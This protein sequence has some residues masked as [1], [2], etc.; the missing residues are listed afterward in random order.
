[1]VHF[2]DGSVK[3]QMGVPD[4]RVPILYSLSYPD[5]LASDLP[6][7]DLSRSSPLSFFS[8]DL[9]RFRNLRLAYHA[10][11]EGG[12]MPCILNAANEVAVNAFLAGRIGF[13]QMSDV[14]EHTMEKTEY[15]ASPGL[16][17]LETTNSMARTEARNYINELCK[18]S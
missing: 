16:G 1:M 15:L 3:A 7:L 9:N 17:F 12:N 6:K 5:R 18:Q 10:L 13:L 2:A 14:V 8:P 4:M 11:N